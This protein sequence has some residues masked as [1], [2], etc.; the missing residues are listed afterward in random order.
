MTT[1]TTQTFIQSINISSKKMA[2]TQSTTAPAS[3][4]STNNTST[5]STLVPTPI[6]SPSDSGDS[7][8]VVINGR[9]ARNLAEKH[10]RDKLNAS[11]GELAKMVPHVADSPRRL[12]KTSVLRLTTHGLRLHYVFGKS[13]TRRKSLYKGD[14]NSMTNTL[15]QLL[16]SFFITLTCHGQIVL[17]SSSVE[18][19]L[20]HCQSDLYGQ[21]LLQITH[22]EDQEM[23]RQ[24]LIPSDI[25]SLFSDYQNSSRKNA[26]N[27]DTSFSNFSR[28]QRSYTTSQPHPCAEECEC[29]RKQELENDENYLADIDEKLKSDK[30]CFTVRLARAS[31]RS[32]LRKVYEVV[33]IDGCFR[34]SDFSTLASGS[35]NYPIVSQLIRRSRNSSSSS[36]SLSSPMC[37]SNNGM[38]TRVFMPH[39]LQHDAIAQAALHGVSGNDIVLV[40]MARIIRSP[41]IMNY[42][43]ESNRLEYKTRHLIDGR[44]VDCDNR[45]GLVAGYLKDEVNFYSLYSI[46]LKQ[47]INVKSF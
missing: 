25:E 35:C 4:I 33:K 41:Q 30:R 29:S 44:I 39:L 16:D 43:L 18:N 14:N 32:E 27:Q 31:N 26:S 46:S 17:I 22:P 23:L 11:I 45:I 38:G 2:N 34:R 21:N 37:G 36:S 24:E 3:S 10:R 15:L 5:A 40:A 20:G 12:D 13:S 8:S 28:E 7:A 6:V 42:S 1:V 19:L 47:I 9:E